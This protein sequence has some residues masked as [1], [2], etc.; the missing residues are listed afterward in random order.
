MHELAVTRNLLDLVLVEAR[1]NCA[2]SVRSIH[3]VVGELTGIVPESVTFYFPYLSRDT[4]ASQASLTFRRVKAQGRCRDC[5]EAFPFEDHGWV[6]PACGTARFEVV[7]GNELC[8]ESIEID[9]DQAE[10][11]DVTLEGS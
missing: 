6:C 11:D 8:V 7:S 4:I 10:E 1:K 9:T 5:G 2:V 3:V